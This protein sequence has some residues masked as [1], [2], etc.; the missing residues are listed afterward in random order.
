M[1]QTLRSLIA[2]L[3][4]LMLV[5]SLAPAAL[6]EDET[7][8]QM[9]EADEENKDVSYDGSIVVENA[10]AAL[11]VYASNGFTANVDVAGDI[12]G[13]SDEYYTDGI[14]A[15]A[16]SEG[17]VEVHVGGD[18]ISDSVED[19]YVLNLGIND[20][21]TV[22]VTVDGSLTATA[23][24]SA[25]GAVA[26]LYADDSLLEVTVGQDVTVTSE[27]D[28]ARGIWI[29]VYGDNDAIVNVGGDVNVSVTEDVG[30]ATGIRVSGY[31]GNTEVTVGGTVI[32][33]ALESDG[34]TT[35]I[36]AQVGDGT[37]TVEAGDTLAMVTEGQAVGVDA[38]TYEDGEV[39]VTINGDVY[40]E[41]AENGA[42]TGINAEAYEGGCIDVT[43]EGGAVAVTSK[44]QA[45]GIGATAE[46]ESEVN[47]TVSDDVY[48]EVADIGYAVGVNAAA[49]EGNTNV[50]VDGTVAA[51]A[52]GNG[53]SAGIQAI[54]SNGG[55]LLVVVEGDVTGYVMD[56][57]AQSTGVYM[58][59]R[60]MEYG[61]D[62]DEDEYDLMGAY[63]E[64]DEPVEGTPSEPGTVSVVIGGTLFSDGAPVIIGDSVTAE[65][66]ENG[67]AKLTVWQVLL[68]EGQENIVSRMNVDFDLETGELNAELAQDEVTEAFEKAIQ[69]IIRVED[70]DK[71]TLTLEGTQ[72]EGDYDVALEGDA[73]ALKVNVANGYKLNGVY[74]GLEERLLLV[75]GDDGSYSVVVP[76]CG[77]VYLSLDLALARAL[78][79][80]VRL[81]AADG[82]PVYINF[83]EDGLYEVIWGNT[84]DHGHF[85]VENGVLTLINRKKAE[86]KVAADGA[87]TYV[88]PNGSEVQVTLPAETLTK[89]L[90]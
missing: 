38:V 90:G 36:Y 16:D 67:N 82:T 83:F 21:G 75:A 19:P 43:V 8:P 65:D 46:G 27:E 62:E 32:A 74:S 73:V 23:D 2:M 53:T 15:Y 17:V 31:S 78:L 52:A 6:A 60:I 28:T 18:V 26:S 12:I 70:T 84:Y 37:T 1:K 58:D 24:M 47:V 54:A 80:N 40:A 50:Y 86:M 13:K 5:F 79:S 57:S 77:G 55:S 44:G 4:A 66:V 33:S 22:K 48:A 68:S 71:A 20:T 69:Y 72:K 59:V 41:V 7:T 89:L 11:E 9:I 61:Y 39:D 10:D 29:S 85:A 25:S 35:G 51:S 34:P 63:G 87:L 76:W 3:M 49:N 30:Y 88:F 56:E 45:S 42:A 14:Q 81:T 64:D